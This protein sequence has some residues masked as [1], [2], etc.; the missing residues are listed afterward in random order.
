M[1]R[2]PM[3]EN[4]CTDEGHAF[5]WDCLHNGCADCL[6]KWLEEHTDTLPVHAGIDATGDS[7][8]Q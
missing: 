4:R 8:G 2:I 3:A 5:K 6:Q 7:H 1:C